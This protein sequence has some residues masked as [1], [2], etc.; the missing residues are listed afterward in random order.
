MVDDIFFGCIRNL[1]MIALLN[2][3]I[4]DD[5]CGLT[6]VQKFFNMS[7]F[8]PACF[9]LLLSFSLSRILQ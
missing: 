7:S 3:L 4:I 8:F 5:V 9:P 1:L 2:G 6:F